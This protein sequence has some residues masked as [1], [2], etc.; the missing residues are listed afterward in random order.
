MDEAAIERIVDLTEQRHPIERG[1]DFERTGRYFVRDG[2]GNYHERRA[3]T[4]RP[5]ARLF[6]T[7]SLG[8]LVKQ[9]I[10]LENIVEVYYS[11]DRIEASVYDAAHE[12]HRRHE[13]LLER[14]PV[15]TRLMRL[16]RTEVFTQ[17]QL[18]RLLRAEFNGHV[19][20]SVIETFRVLDLKTDGDNS[21]VVRQGHEAVDK[22]VLQRIRASGG[23]DVPT[24]IVV[25]VPVY[26]LDESRDSE[27]DVM[28]LVDATADENSRPV[29][30]LTA[31]VNDLRVAE[32]R[33]LDEIVESLAEAMPEGVDLFYG[34]V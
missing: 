18:I 24:E 9:E 32:R 3:V 4:P 10:E 15:F 29:F 16:V 19:G 14:H 30:E 13:I 6:D 7:L 5:D 12:L 8:S 1:P 2:A 21:S 23:V 27:Y 17:K 31:V 34:S 22:K 11:A 33:A 25:S 28:L 20:E 26:D